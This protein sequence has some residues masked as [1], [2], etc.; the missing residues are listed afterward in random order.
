MQNGWHS[1]GV[2][3]QADDKTTLADAPGELGH[4]VSTLDV[5]RVAKFSVSNASQIASST[6]H[7]NS[8]TPSVT[9]VLKV[10]NLQTRPMFALARHVVVAHSSFLQVA[11]YFPN[12]QMYHSW[13][14]TAPL[15][16]E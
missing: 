16:R 8:A 6:Q 1:P 3:L 7:A 10:L 9:L 14:S 15:L 2:V 4:Q 11:L 13:Q 12:V 5:A